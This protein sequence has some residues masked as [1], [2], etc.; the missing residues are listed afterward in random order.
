MVSSSL[1]TQSQKLAIESIGHIVTICV[2][3]AKMFF[4][5]K[6]ILLIQMNESVIPA[7]RI[8]QYLLRSF[9]DRAG[10][11]AKTIKNLEKKN[12]IISECLGAYLEFKRVSLNYVL[13]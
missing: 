6:C 8:L 10:K 5:R 13:N 12:S 9:N 1:S 4:I 3:K 11:L 2:P 7:Q